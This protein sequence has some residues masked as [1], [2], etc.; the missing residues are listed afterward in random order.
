[1]DR[2][3]TGLAPLGKGPHQAHLVGLD[4]RGMSGLAQ[5]LVQRGFVVTGSVSTSAPGPT[6]DR[7]RRLGVRVHAGHSPRSVPRSARLLVYSP[8]VP[9]EHPDRLSAALSGIEQRSSPSVL[10]GLLG[11][12]IGIAAVG[13]RKAGLAA[14]MVGWTLTHAGLDPTVLL[15]TPSPQLGGCGRLGLGPHVIVEEGERPDESGLDG[16]AIVILHDESDPSARSE[17]LR[18]W[19]EASPP[20]GYVLGFADERDAVV[21][22][23]GPTSAVERFSLAPGHAWWGAD[24]RHDRGCY[25]F[26]AF[27]RGRFA[28]EVRLQVPGRHLVLGALAAVA[29][30]GRVDLTCRA[31]KEALEEFGGISRGFESRGSYRGVTLIDD[32]ADGPR[33]VAEA[34]AV[35][36]EVFGPRRLCVA[37]RRPSGVDHLGPFS[38]EFAS[39]DRV[40]VIDGEGPSGESTAGALAEALVASGLVVGR[41]SGLEGAIRELDRHLEPGD[42]LVTLGAGEVGTIADAFLR[43]LPS[44][45]HA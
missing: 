18:R 30:C 21:P 7:L 9:R 10:A 23:M 27:H 33:G 19:A 41:A 15:G 43:R 37:Y 12:G 25:R 44:N 34:L 1:M 8:E 2:T 35:A 24:L 13:G 6:T 22:E 42:V 20:G 45:R 4:G 3:G 38:E 40:W 26:R 5:M 14:A 31:I 32:E 29:V 36:R 17:S 39:A 11:G 16:L 28:L